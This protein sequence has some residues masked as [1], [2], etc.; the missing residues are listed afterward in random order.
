MIRRSSIRLPFQLF[1]AACCVAVSSR[2]AAAQLPIPK[3][4]IVGGVSHS[5]GETTPIG[6]LR[7]AVP[8]I[9]LVA[10]GSLGVMH[11]DQNGTSATYII[12]EVQLQYQFLPLV[13]RPY[14]GAGGGWFRGV[15]GPDPRVNAGTVSAAAGV[16]VSPPLIG[17]GLSGEVRVRHIGGGFNSSA[18]EFT[19]GISF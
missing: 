8:L 10:E 12:P 17:F 5:G 3:F 11:P 16:R 4:G 7:V 15:S 19:I 14:I 2:A 18:T 1:L 6:E 13:V 9:A